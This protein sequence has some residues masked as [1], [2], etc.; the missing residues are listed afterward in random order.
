MVEQISLSLQVK[1]SVIIFKKLLYASCI[2]SCRTILEVDLRKLG[3]IRKSPPP[4]MKIL[5]VQVK[6]S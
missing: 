2:K 4:E 3:N 6:V 5:S 1:R